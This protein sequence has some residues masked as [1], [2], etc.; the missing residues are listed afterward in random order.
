[1]KKVLVLLFLLLPSFAF[2]QRM[3]FSVGLAYEGEPRLTA[4][5]CLLPSS[6]SLNGGTR[7]DTDYSGS[8]VV[9]YPLFLRLRFGAFTLD[10]G[11]GID[12]TQKFAS[13]ATAGAIFG[14]GAFSIS[15]RGGVVYRGGIAPLIELGLIAN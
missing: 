9:F 7:M 1:M 6:V 13:F 12:K 15:I 3:S 14:L 2:C 10:A 4:E 11:G 5:T 8:D